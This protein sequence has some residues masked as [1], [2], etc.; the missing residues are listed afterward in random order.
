MKTLNM[1]GI[2]TVIRPLWLLVWIV[3]GLMGTVAHAQM[4]TCPKGDKDEAVCEVD[5][6]SIQDNFV[7]INCQDGK[8]Q[9]QVQKSCSAVF[10]PIQGYTYTG[11]QGRNWI[12]ESKLTITS[13]E[14]ENKKLVCS[15]LCGKC[16]A[17]WGSKADGP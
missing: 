15:L 3:I 9:P 1:K 7:Y 11:M 16:N 5:E 2:K 4:Y 13:D 6:R 10:T 12:C 8:D 17:G 14:Y